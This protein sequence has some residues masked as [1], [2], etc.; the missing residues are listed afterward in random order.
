MKKFST[1]LIVALAA[2]C[3]GSPLGPGVPTT[4][5][6]SRQ[7]VRSS[8]SSPI[9][10]VVVIMQENRSFDNFFH[11][12]PKA[13]SAT[14]GM[15]HGVKYPLQ[16]LHLKWTHDM[17]HYR[18]QFLEDL[19]NGKN[20]GF[21][22]QIIG[23]TKDCP[24]PDW[25]NH[26]SCFVFKTGKVYLKMAYSYVMKSDI[27]PYW[28][29]AQQYTLGD[30]NFT[31]NNG[32]SFGAHQYMIGGQAGHAAEVP[33]T[34]PWGCDAPKET[35]N[36]LQAGPADPPEFPPAFGHEVMNGP[37]PC[38]TYPTAA[39]LLDKA[40]VTWRY[41]V[42]KKY[43]DG[44]W[45]SA[46]DA[47]GAVRNGPDWS[48]V[49]SPD[50][51][52]LDDIKNHT[53]QHVSWV[54]PHGG[55]S[56]HAGGGSGA[57]GPDWVASIVNAIGQSSYWNSTAIIITWDEWGGWYDHVKPKQYPDPITGAYEGLGYRTP[58]IIVS[59]YAKNH[60]VSKSQHETAS[61]LHFI[62]KTFGLG[63]LGL[64]DKRADAYDDVF[65]YSKQPTKFAR[66]KP[67]NNGVACTPSQQFEP[68]EDY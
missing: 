51:A 43:N 54:M 35:L 42:Q 20:D 28:T 40:G 57:G 11:G 49:V 59:P 18:Y 58:L 19:D 27:Q 17:N 45:L 32:P 66:I 15:G 55:A 33:S 63:S 22:N 3:A 4:A 48:N 44:Y 64:A 8:P 34:M 23:V 2:G 39:D 7:A 21:D 61:S 56:D 10:Y 37:D 65:D 52:V 36:Y 29:M 1:F 12:F 68:E 13:D 62:E 47:I 46:F 14:F 41:Y 31:S 60:Y 67:N 25:A 24:Y 53:L 50:C 9:K 26:P 30:H 5:A 6:R 38:F 16:P